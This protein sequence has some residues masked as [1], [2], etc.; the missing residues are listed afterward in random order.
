MVPWGPLERF[1]QYSDVIFADFDNDGW[2]DFVVLDRAVDEFV[3]GRSILFMNKGDGTFDPKPTTVSGLN[4]TSISAEAADLNNDGLVDLLVSADPDNT[5]VVY[6]ARAFESIVFMNSGA[7]GGC[8]NHWIRFAFEGVSDAQLIGTRVVLRDPVTGRILGT[9][10]IYSNHSYKS[11]SALE[12]HF[13]LGR[14][15]RVDVEFWLPGGRL[16]KLKNVEG[17]RYVRV[18]LSTATLRELPRARSATCMR[19]RGLFVSGKIFTRA[20]RPS[21]PGEGAGVRV[22]GVRERLLPIRRDWRRSA[23]CRG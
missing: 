20:H 6:D 7:H 2:Q 10:G 3:Q 14:V 4:A 1:P 5:G 8:K 17:D 16:V 21:P 13:G 18:D 15:E 12:A 22:G 23:H 9:R 19:D 11:S